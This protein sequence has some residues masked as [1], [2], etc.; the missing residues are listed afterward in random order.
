MPCIKAP[1]PDLPTLPDG[2]S[3]NAPRPSLPGFNA[4]LCC[5]LFNFTFP[6]IPP[7]GVAIPIEVATLLNE[8]RDQVQAYFKLLSFDCPRE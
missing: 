2:F 8:G 5:K 7:I 6:P 1:V 4:E 3:V